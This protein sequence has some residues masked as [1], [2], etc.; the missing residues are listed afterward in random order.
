MRRLEQLDRLLIDDMLEEIKY[1][2]VEDVK[3]L[4]EML[5]KVIIEQKNIDLIRDILEE[6]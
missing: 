1:E 3:I 2:D 5:L 6:R 4:E